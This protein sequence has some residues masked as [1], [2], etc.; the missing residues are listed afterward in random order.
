MDDELERRILDW[1]RYHPY[2]TDWQL[3]YIL[4]LNR[5]SMKLY[6]TLKRMKSEGKIYGE[7]VNKRIVVTSRGLSGE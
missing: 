1:L 4:G 6:S 7:R 2:L 5:G 3:E